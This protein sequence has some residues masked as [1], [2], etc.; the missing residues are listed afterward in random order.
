MAFLSLAENAPLMRALLVLAVALLL[1]VAPIAGG[2]SPAGTA[3][4]IETPEVPDDPRVAT[5][6]VGV[7]PVL[8]PTMAEPNS[9]GPATGSSGA[10]STDGTVEA[11]SVD[12]GNLTLRVLSTQPDVT[13]RVGATQ[14]DAN[15][16]TAL[17]LSVGEVDAALRTETTLQRI[18]SAE[19]SAERQRRILAAINEVEQDEVS[20]DSR[21]TAAMNAHANGELTDRELLD[22]LVRVAAVAAE[23]D[24]RLDLLDEV[25]EETDG[26][27]SPGRLDELQV[28]L[29]VYEG[30]VRERALETVRGDT[31]GAQIHVESSQQAVVLATVDGDEYVRE[32]FRRDRWDRGGGTLSSEAAIDAAIASY[33][34]TTALREPDAF[35][36]GS[37][38]RITV[39][40]EFGTL[41]SFV[42]GGT[43]QVFVEHQRIGLDRF[44][45]ADTVSTTEDGFN[46]TVD[47]SYPGGPVTVTVRDAETGDPVSDI[48][49]T[50]SVDGG[51]SETIGATNADGVVRALSP[52]ETYR[53]TV[54]D[55]PR[56]AVINGIQPIETPRLTDEGGS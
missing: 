25:A 34:E 10:P 4:D 5:M 33:P 2:T 23:Y 32:A 8:G 19:D 51:D 16:G 37:V 7:S 18:E 49:V 17:D 52:A 39:P 41:R 28:Q 13:P 3:A 9:D 1:F 15:L 22:E 38:Q 30:P 14:R 47:R 48:T 53:I 29:Q 43:E 50:K 44:P 31:P 56:V 12:E 11:A 42:S 6:D 54:I 46:V 24:H 36:A 27:S 55:E 26:F 21:Q 35:G 45:D 40:H 20:L